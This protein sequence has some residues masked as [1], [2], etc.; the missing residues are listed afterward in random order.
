MTLSQPRLTARGVALVAAAYA[1]LAVFYAVTIEWY[2]LADGLGPFLANVWGELPRML[3][4]YTL[5]GALTLPVWWLVVCRL[6]G[7]PRLQIAAHAVLGPVWVWAWFALYHGLAEPMG[8]YVLESGRSAWD[9]YIPALVY[10]AQFG[11]FH[12]WQ[13][14]REVRRRA[15]A[16]TALVDAARHAELA[17]LKAQLNPHFLF[18]TL[19]SISASVPP[20]QEHTRG[21]VSRLAHLMRYALD[22]SRRD[23]VLLD[24]ELRF[25]EAYLALEAERLGDRLGVEWEVD[26]DARSVLVPPMLVQPLVENAV[27]HGIAPSLEGG[28]VTIRARLRE[29]TLAMEIRDSGRGLDADV[30]E[31]EILSRGVGLGTTDARLRALGA[32]G[33][34]LD[35]TP[36]EPGFAVRFAL[37]VSEREALAPTSPAS[38]A[39]RTTPSPA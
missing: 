13:Y 30:N 26:A 20:E 25:T 37:E 36:G 6:N 9:V 2:E 28:T 1:A 29:T 5:K 39:A 12:A 27:R 16:E 32:G 19:N 35:A 21:L 11:A 7:R 33:V 31:H 14:V 17:A 22:A 18:N 10:L 4:D 8:Y 3:W 23:A 34:D 38:V 15:E 24:E